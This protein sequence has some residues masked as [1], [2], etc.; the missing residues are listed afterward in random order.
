MVQSIQITS[1]PSKQHK[2]N[3]SPIAFT[4][5]DAQR[6]HHL[7]DNALVIALSV[8]NYTTKWILVDNGSLVDILHYKAF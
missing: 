8:S 3:G 6:L 7:H 2:L 5:E 4:D 1:R